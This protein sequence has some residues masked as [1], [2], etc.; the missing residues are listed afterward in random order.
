LFKI[1]FPKNGNGSFNLITGTPD[2]YLNNYRI[3]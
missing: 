2:G 1:N 3:N